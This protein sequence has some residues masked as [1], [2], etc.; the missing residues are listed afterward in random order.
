MAKSPTTGQEI[1]FL[2]HDIFD[3]IFALL[4]L[5]GYKSLSLRRRYDEA[6]VAVYK[7]V[8]KLCKTNNAFCGFYMVQ[9]PIHGDSQ[10]ARDSLREWCANGRMYICVPRDGTYQFTISKDIA[11]TILERSIEFTG[12]R[13]E[14]FKD[15][16]LTFLNIYES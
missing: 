16:T 3:A 14:N 12:L 8:E 4:I 15:L 11:E 10:V 1:E 2:Q 5:R 6:C 7:E 13:K 9:H